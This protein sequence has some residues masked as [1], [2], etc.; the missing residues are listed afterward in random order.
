MSDLDQE[1]KGQDFMPVK[2]PNWWQRFLMWLSLLRP[3]H[4]F[5]L[6]L[7]IILALTGV[8]YFSLAAL[9]K[10]DS[11]DTGG[12]MVSEDD[13]R[14]T[15][16]PTDLV[17]PI[18]NGALFLY[19][20]GGNFEEDSTFDIDVYLKSASVDI[21]AIAAHIKYD[22]A[23]L[24]L[25]SVITTDEFP[26]SGVEDKNKLEGSYNLI[27]GTYGNGLD[28]DGNLAPE[29]DYRGA[30]G[31]LPVAT[32]HFRALAT[33]NNATTTT[34]I[35]LS[36]IL[37][38]EDDGAGSTLNFSATTTDYNIIPKKAFNA[39]LNISNLNVNSVKNSD[40]TWDV[41]IT[42][43]TNREST[44][45]LAGNPALSKPALTTTHL[46]NLSSL[47]AG[48]YNHTVISR[49]VGLDD[50]TAP[51]EFTLGAV[52]DELIIK[53]L[54]A[55][56]SYN[57]ANISWNTVGG[58]HNGEADGNV[59]CHI[60]SDIYSESNL[61]LSHVFQIGGLTGGTSYT[62][63]VSSTDESGATA[64]GSVSFTTKNGL[65]FDSNIVLKVEP[66][67]ICDKWLYCRSEVEVVNTKNLKEN[68]C[69][70]LGICDEKDK[71]GNCVASG[72]LLN[73]V[74]GSEQT[75][76]HPLAVNSI[77]NLSGLAKVGLDWGDNK[78]INGYYNYTNMKTTGLDLYIPNADFESGSVWPWQADSNNNAILEI[79]NKADSQVLV[80]KPQVGVSSSSWADA[81]IS[82]GT[83]TQAKGYVYAIS[84]GLWTSGQARDVY[85]K[86]KIG[87][88]Q[89]STVQ[90]VRINSYPQT[91]VLISNQYGS[92][93]QDPTSGSITGEGT[94]AVSV[95]K[96]KDKEY[97]YSDQFYV[98]NVSMKAVL[99]VSSYKIVAR[100]CRLYPSGDAVACDYNDSSGKQLRGW[101][102]FC[103]EEDPQTSEQ[104]TSQKMCLNW[105]PV[106]ILPGETDIFGKN[107]TA[108]YLGRE[109]LYY[110]VEAAGNYPYVRLTRSG[111]T[112]DQYKASLMYR[113]SIF[114]ATVPG[115]YVPTIITSVAGW[116]RASDRWTSL[117]PEEKNLRKID[118]ER[119]VLTPL[120]EEGDDD[121]N[122][123]S[124]KTNA[125]ATIVLD[126]DAD[127]QGFMC[128]GSNCHDA[129]YY[130]DPDNNLW[131]TSAQA[132]MINNDEK[133]GNQGVDFFAVRATFDD[134]GNFIGLQSGLCNT[135]DNPGYV[136]YKTSFYLREV[137]NV[138]A[139]VVTPDGENAA[140]A[141]R[142]KEGGW[143]INQSN[144]LGYGYK[145]DYEPY[146]AAVAGGDVTDPGT[147]FNPLYVMPAETEIGFDLPYQVRAGSP[148]GVDG[149]IQ[150]Y[151]LT[152]TKK[153]NPCTEARDCNYLDTSMQIQWGECGI[154]NKSLKIGKAQC[155]S[156]EAEKLGTTCNSSLD[157]GYS[158]DGSGSGICMGINL[159]TQAINNLAGGFAKGQEILQNL[160]AKSYRIWRWTADGYV[161][162]KANPGYG[163][164]ITKDAI[165]LANK[166]TLASIEVN[167]KNN[168]A[169]ITI[170]NL[171]K[172]K[173]TFRAVVD[174]NHLPLVAYRIDWGDGTPISQVNNLKIDPNNKDITLFHS[175]SCQ[176][177]SC[178]YIPKI[179]IQDNWGWCN[180]GTATN[181]C[182]ANSISNCDANG[183]C[184][185]T[186]TW[187]PFDGTITIE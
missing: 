113:D 24:S 51:V 66:D 131:S 28:G 70:D 40:D 104:E 5:V 135:G 72:D 81:E 22:P 4:K 121:R 15:A 163:W 134:K 85:V 156:G 57:S 141:N 43:D 178:T 129:A 112:A 78:I 19:P 8:V 73:L 157:C 155:I 3:K 62:C 145:S 125:K 26:Q 33:I 54:T 103:V 115:T 96:D 68:L 42:W 98:D 29:L 93:F 167:G 55:K 162:S 48:T 110:C 174:L 36:N 9:I 106:D 83:I 23:L 60:G 151:C 67:R 92:E 1:I 99:Q 71:F 138:V 111:N 152:G 53:N 49:L 139:E 37:A 130:F 165:Y 158:Y 109:P 123:F 172:V 27:R 118:I 77:E 107:Q 122:C 161:E 14:V 114:T 179:Q 88:R 160:F 124:K 133:C 69:F 47:T 150:K 76:K 159:G 38:V 177:D 154:T 101:K 90:K 143:G 173:L 175:Y 186:N 94:L 50:A 153:D 116:Q 147:W 65:G 7:I 17:I 100:S 120:C 144:I 6:I 20:S 64:S 46:I 31:V 18:E 89:F 180:N 86:L 91:I 128:N 30:R 16:L 82:L 56:P 74:S 166:P 80:V 12:S 44:T 185:N 11:E 170:T 140:W 117:A 137:C 41:E 32:L 146:G 97:A 169:G 182:P 13:N 102:G 84:M 75:Y 119:I 171:Q 21:V 176:E 142:V 149:E 132:S 25:E 164:D 34:D 59:D 168:K 58:A 183:M 105:W 181:R 87:D 95:F 79:Q 126:R 52:T 127:W 184:T 2:K 35:S 108:G 61:T 45:E 10:Y 187:E 148:Y 39:A 136:R 63:D